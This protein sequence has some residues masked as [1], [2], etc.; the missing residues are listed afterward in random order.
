MRFKLKR[1]GHCKIDKPIT[2]F[3][4]FRG[5]P[6]SWCKTCK[7]EGQH[8]HYVTD[9]QFRV[10]RKQYLKKYRE[11]MTR[12]QKRRHLKAHSRNYRNKNR[13]LINKNLKISYLLTSKGIR[14]T[15]IKRENSQC[16]RCKVKVNTK[17]PN[18][19]IHHINF[20]RKNNDPINLMLLC[21]RCHYFIHNSPIEVIV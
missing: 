4:L 1:C 21:S 8:I 13:E 19:A 16:Q 14:E 18:Y 9:P 7:L 12:E 15:V 20:D 6:E 11:T 5:K 17:S 10:R 3:Y 2:D